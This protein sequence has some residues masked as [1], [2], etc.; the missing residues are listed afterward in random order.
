MASYFVEQRIRTAQHQ[1]E[2]GVQKTRH[3]AMTT[4]KPHRIH[5]TDKGYEIF[6]ATVADRLNPEPITTENWNSGVQV[7]EKI[8]DTPPQ[9]VLPEDWTITPTGLCDPLRFKITYKDSWM[10]FSFHPLNGTIQE[11]EFKME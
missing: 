10:E 7:R 1:L 8:P 5:F 2:L 4:Q 3:L 9:F 6:D 11:V